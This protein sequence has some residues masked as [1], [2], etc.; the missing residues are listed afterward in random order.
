MIIFH[1]FYFRPYKK[2]STFIPH[3]IL[4]SAC[5]FFFFF[6]KTKDKTYL[7]DWNICISQIIQ[8]NFNC[9]NIYYLNYTPNSHNYYSVCITSNVQKN[10]AFLLHYMCFKIWGL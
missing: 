5:L 7:I 6:Y 8:P 2:P 1:Q 10:M 9:G 4:S 3:P